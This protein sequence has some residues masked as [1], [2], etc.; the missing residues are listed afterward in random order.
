MNNVLHLLEKKKKTP[1]RHQQQ[2][3][4]D[5]CEAKIVFSFWFVQ[6]FDVFYFEYA[7]VKRNW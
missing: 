3:I 4:V 6:F 2:N 5:N 7:F 1:Q